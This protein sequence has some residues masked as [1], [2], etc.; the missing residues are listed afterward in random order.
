MNASVPPATLRPLG[1]GEILDRAV[2]LCVRYFMPFA[3]IYLA[4]GIPLGVVNYFATRNLTTLYAAMIDQIKA[5]ASGHAPDSHAYADA[6]ANASANPG[7]SLALIAIVFFVSPLMT[8]ALVDATSE[9]YLGRVPTFARAYRIALGRWLNVIGINLMY[10]L[11]A[12]AMY[13]VVVLAVVVL[14]FGIVAISSA[15]HA[16]G[17]GVVVG[18]VFAIFAFGVGLVV[19]LAYQVS[20]FACVVEK[21]NFAAAFASGMSRVWRGV[22]LK[23]S[24][25]V[26]LAYVAVVIGISLVSSVGVALLLGVLRSA[27]VGVAFGVLIALGTAALLTAF[28]AVFYYDLRVREDGLDLALEAGDVLARP[29]VPEP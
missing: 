27:V 12:G 19:A 1:I 17:V 4:Y 22:G 28:M 10:L 25:L 11:A 2:T 7:W 5:Q 3:L 16:V 13:L 29:I 23:R 8:A 15:A 21:A 14:V 26:G 24:L 18:V 6:L 9:S 20:C